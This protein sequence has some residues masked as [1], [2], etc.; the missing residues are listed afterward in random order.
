MVIW[1]RCT[2]R[3]LFVFFIISFALFFLLASN[4]VSFPSTWCCF[5][6]P[7]AWS[8]HTTETMYAESVVRCSC[9]L[10]II[11]FQRIGFLL[12]FK[13][14]VGGYIDVWFCTL[15]SFL[16]M[17]LYIIVLNNPTLSIFVC[18]FEISR[19]FAMFCPCLYIENWIS[20]CDKALLQRTFQ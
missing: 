2:F 3:F 11:H 8:K 14:C 4:C 15:G 19:S 9:L 18:F 12:L 5:L 17:I 6:L 1:L 16:F 10:S 7:N 20:F 13:T